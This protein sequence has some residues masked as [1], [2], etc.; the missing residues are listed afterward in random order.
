MRR[1]ERA[2]ARNGGT[3]CS[4]ANACRGAS[5]QKTCVAKT[6]SQTRA[7]MVERLPTEERFRSNRVFQ[8]CPNC[9]LRAD[10]SLHVA[11]ALIRCAHCNVRFQVARRDA[12]MP[13]AHAPDDP[14]SW[15]ELA[16]VGNPNPLS[17]A[18]AKAA[19]PA[20][21]GSPPN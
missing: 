9:D 17:A 11:G 7:R 20:P 12:A 6:G 4:A 21:P 14:S 1:I 10:V 5:R 18:K 3:H 8:R 15:E 2:G 19:P 16:A 13:Q